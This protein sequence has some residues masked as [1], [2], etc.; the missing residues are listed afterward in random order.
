MHMDSNK[1]KVMVMVKV[2]EHLVAGQQLMPR[3]CCVRTG[4]RR[5]PV[6]ME[7]AVALLME[8]NRSRAARSRR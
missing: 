7:T 4:L 8:R 3:L 2:V 5:D 1:V 6:V